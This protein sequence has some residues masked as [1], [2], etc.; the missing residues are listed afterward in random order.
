MKIKGLHHMSAITA[1]AKKNL[2][3]YTNILG[4]R[5]VKKTVNQDSSSMYHLFYA[6]EK[7]N[8]GTDVTFFEIPLAGQTYK[9]TNSISLTSLRVPTDQA[10]VYWKSR[11]E[12]FH[13]SHEE[14]REQAGRSVLPFTDFEGQRL[15]LVSDEH[16]EGVAG[17]VPWEKSPVPQEYGII[18]LGPSRLTVENAEETDELL[19]NILGF[20]KKG[21]YPSET[22][23]QPDI[24][25]YET[26][27]G[28]TGAEIHVEHRTDL[29]RE[30]PGRGSV[31]HIA[32]RVEDEKE[33]HAFIDKLNENG[34]PNSQYV[35][36][37]YFRSVYLKD[38]N[39]LTIELATDGP[40]FD[41]DEELE[42][43]G[44]SLALPPFLENRREEIESRLKPL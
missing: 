33:L 21:S 4:M 7:G 8:P 25:I 12:E 37:Y 19:T 44:E 15:L 6:D 35:D 32:L 31:H 41:T 18:G 14:I 28:G 20:H 40:G 23:G 24:V 26:A 11:F 10:L 27:E 43:L 22:E 16:N 36:R 9:G 34:I 3:F 5:L 29:P 30:R 2:D 17:G 38:P 13:V 1:N 39:G 42:F